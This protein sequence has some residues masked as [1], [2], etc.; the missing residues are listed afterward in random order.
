MVLLSNKVIDADLHPLLQMFGQKNLTFFPVI[1]S[2]CLHCLVGF[3][4]T[5]GVQC[6]SWLL[7]KRK[8][9]L[10]SHS[11]RTSVGEDVGDTD[12]DA[13]G[14]TVGD[15]DLHFVLQIVGQRNFAIFPV[16]GSFFLHRLIGFAKIHPSQS[17]S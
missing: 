13:V 16:T 17:L 3:A 5:H 15:L 14:N 8:T 7:L 11:P 6:L 12:D 9:S 10:F 1:G 4:E 2:V